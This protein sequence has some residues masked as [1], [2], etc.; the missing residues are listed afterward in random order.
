M[1]L[2]FFDN[3]LS[4]ICNYLIKGK[5]EALLWIISILSLFLKI[6]MNLNKRLQYIFP[7]DRN[8]DFHHFLPTLM[9]AYYLFQF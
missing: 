8:F 6:E 2:S 1:K 7:E 9:F 5:S 3:Q 4:G